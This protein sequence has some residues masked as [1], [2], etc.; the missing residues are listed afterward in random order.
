MKKKKDLRREGCFSPWKVA[1]ATAAINKGMPTS[2]TLSPS[3]TPQHRSIVLEKKNVLGK[4]A[5]LGDIPAIEKTP[6][7]LKYATVS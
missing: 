6:L 1:L 2:C 3:H 7:P 5:V 4:G